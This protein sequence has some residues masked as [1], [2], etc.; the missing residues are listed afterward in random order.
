MKN[1]SLEHAKSQERKDRPV[2]VNNPRKRGIEGESELPGSQSGNFS[3][4]P[5]NTRPRHEKVSSGGRV[6]DSM[7]QEI[8][9]T[10]SDFKRD[11]SG[12]TQTLFNPHTDSPNLYRASR[13]DKQSGHEH[14]KHRHNLPMD[15]L[16][17]EPGVRLIEKAHANF[18]VQRGPNR[19]SKEEPRNDGD[20]QRGQPENFDKDRDDNSSES[21]PA[22][23]FQGSDH[24]DVQDTQPEMLLQPE[25]RPISHDQL[26]VE[27]KGI[28]AGL[29]M[30]EAKCIDIDE[31]QS[32]A[33][34]EKDLSKR[35]ELKNDQWQ[36]LIALHKQVSY[37]SKRLNG[38]RTIYLVYLPLPS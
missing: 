5:M 37:L 8:S 32:A 18:T 11:S 3:G 21:P 31:R 19:S 33:A 25:T 4:A 17:P 26:V 38:S 20:D 15:V 29:V 16:S 14:P 23:D 12:P 22:D 34:Q 7:R 36:S 13:R 10:D 2:L 9:P 30:V 35:H 6:M 24:A 1:L 27:V 28:Y